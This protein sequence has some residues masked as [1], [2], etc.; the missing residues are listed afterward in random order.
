M[1][2]EQVENNLPFGKKLSHEFNKWI[3]LAPKFS[4]LIDTP[5]VKGLV[6]T[7]LNRLSTEF[8]D[9]FSFYF[10]YFIL[11]RKVMV[12]L[13]EKTCQCGMWQLCKKPCM[14]AV[15]LLKKF[16]ISDLLSYT[17]GTYLASTGLNE[18]L[19]IVFLVNII[20]KKNV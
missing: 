1:F 7:S 16:N 17:D 2:N 20:R 15:V 5:G 11:F 10:S 12:D 8:V 18:I 6:Q 13:S 19:F 3:S 14:H 9:Y 4:I